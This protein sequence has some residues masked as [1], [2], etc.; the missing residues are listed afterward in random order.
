MSNE[1]NQLLKSLIDA[2]TKVV[3]VN[4]ESHAQSVQA[5]SCEANSIVHYTTASLHTMD[6][7]A[8]FTGL[9][10]R[11]KCVVGGQLQLLDGIEM[12]SIG[13]LT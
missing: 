4:F 9:K 8:D 3:N 5:C 6:T 1:V 2:L 7:Q 10:S 11:T 13:R 12:V